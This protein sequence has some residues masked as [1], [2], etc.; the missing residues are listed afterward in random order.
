MLSR[1]AIQVDHEYKEH[2]RQCVFCRDPYISDCDEG[3][4]LL[5]LFYDALRDD[6]LKAS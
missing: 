5:Q 4:R 3:K 6:V 1:D 2:H